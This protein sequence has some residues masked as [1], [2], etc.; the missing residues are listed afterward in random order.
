MKLVISIL[1]AHVLKLY[2]LWTIS[3]WQAC[4]YLTLLCRQY[5]IK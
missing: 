3:T 1:S 5:Y 2:T 4:I